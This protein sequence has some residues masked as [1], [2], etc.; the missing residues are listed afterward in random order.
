MNRR[1]VFAL[2][3]LALALMALD[4]PQAAAQNIDQHFYYKL[5]TQFRGSGWKLDVFADGGPKGDLTRLAPNQD[6][7]GQYWQLR[8]NADG[9]FRLSTQFR[10]PGMCL[11]IFNAAYASLGSSSMNPGKW[12]LGIFNLLTAL[13]LLK[14]IASFASNLGKSCT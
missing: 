12:R 7:P 10:G 2:A 8:K 6:R 11:D 5:S 13:F 9:T 1:R 3:A 14:G 4:I